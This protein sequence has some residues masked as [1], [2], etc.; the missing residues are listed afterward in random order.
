MTQHSKKIS[1]RCLSFLSIL[2][3]FIRPVFAVPEKDLINGRLAACPDKPNCISTE[4]SS[5]LAPVSIN[6]KNPEA[7]WV[8]LQNAITEL[9]GKI[10]SV[11]SDYLWA[12]FQTPVLKFT[13]D[14][15]ARL[16]LT[17]KVIHL[18][19]ASRTGYY[20]FNTNKNRLK[21]LIEWVTKQNPD[22]LKNT[23]E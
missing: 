17:E 18:R 12:T 7:T 5:E 11:R 20:D 8:I 13:D 19:S 21:R 15:E 4:N 22:R 10:E 16:D 23:H 1:W 9:G 6:L 3:I 2:C 14:V